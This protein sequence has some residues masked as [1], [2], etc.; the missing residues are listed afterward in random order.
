MTAPAKLRIKNKAEVNKEI[1]L[2]IA[3]LRDTRI[4]IFREVVWKTFLRVT[5]E[6]PQFS[7]AL[8][9]H[10]TIGIDSPATFYDPNLGDRDLRLAG[11]MAGAQKPR[12]RGDEYWM[13]V[14]RTREKPKLDRIRRGSTVFITN[15]VMGDTDN[16]RSSAN[17]VADLQESAYWM[18]KL[19][20][21]NQPYIVTE[22]A[23]LLVATQ[24][25][26]KKIDPFTWAPAQEILND[27]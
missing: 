9:A 7:G 3:R 18:S 20:G 1:G 16:G 14:A 12:Q 27:A 24:Y 6:S 22:E 19:R 21:V 10:W 26:G 15:G 2:A 5:R 4:A 25:W 13:R 8:V 23:A 17:Y 11:A